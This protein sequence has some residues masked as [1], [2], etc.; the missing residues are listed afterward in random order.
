MTNMLVENDG[1][2][3][4]TSGRTATAATKIAKNKRKSN[5]KFDRDGYTNMFVIGYTTYNHNRS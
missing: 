4:R 1:M 2:G 3:I 5:Y